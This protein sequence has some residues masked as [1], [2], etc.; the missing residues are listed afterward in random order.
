M[1]HGEWRKIRLREK[2]AETCRS[3]EMWVL[4]SANG[5]YE[6]HFLPMFESEKCYRTNM[7]YSEAW[8]AGL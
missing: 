8:S 2:K 7:Q 3:M 6:V 1:E 5:V 4:Y